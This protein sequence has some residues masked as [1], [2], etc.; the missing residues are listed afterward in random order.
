MKEEVK[1]HPEKKECC[2]VFNAMAIRKQTLWDPTKDAYVGFVNYGDVL[3]ELSDMLA[4]EALVFVLVGLRS[5]WKCLIAYFLIDKI[6]ATSQAQ[7]LLKALVL[8]AEIGLKV[9]CL[10]SDGT[11]SNLSTFRLLGCL[12]GLTYESITAKFK[13]STLNHDVFCILDPCHMLKLARNT[14]ADLGS[15]VYADENGETDEIC[16]KFLQHLHDVQENYGMKLA[17][18]LT[19]NHIKYQSHKMKVDFA[20]QTLSSSVSMP[21][22]SSTLLKRM[23]DSKTAKLQSTSSVPLTSCLTSSTHETPSE[24]EVSSH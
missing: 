22:T 24:R 4:S 8:T 5:H 23:P 21:S 20:A 19:S 12:L 13:H 14:L 10:T 7:L 2:L 1:D 17:N 18:K 15:M 6:S 3:P 9:W 16:W 11:S